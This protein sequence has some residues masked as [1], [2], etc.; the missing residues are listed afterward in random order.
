MSLYDIEY[1]AWQGLKGERPEHIVGDARLKFI[2][3]YGRMP[4]ICLTTREIAESL[5]R[6]FH[7]MTIATVTEKRWNLLPY[8]AYVGIAPE[9]ELA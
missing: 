2:H 7:G 8:S 5:P 3:K 6:E 4:D 1:V 9:V